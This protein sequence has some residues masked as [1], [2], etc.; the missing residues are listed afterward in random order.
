[1]LSSSMY[2]TWQKTVGGRL[3]SDLRFGSTITWTNLPLPPLN[4]VQ[5]TRIIAAG[6]K[7]LDARAL[8]PQRSLAQHYNRWGMD[9]ALVQAH[10][11]LDTEVDKAFGAPRR[12]RT[13]LERQE[14][15]F[16]RYS[17]ATAQT[18]L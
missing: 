7:V 8:H 11:A 9:P 3:K 4:E 12:C 16:A 18:V 13:E 1:M 14:L 15:L 6:Q 10:D 2:L 5:R 17:D